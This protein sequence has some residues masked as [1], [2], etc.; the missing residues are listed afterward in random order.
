[1]TTAPKIA[2]TGWPVAHSRSP[3]VQ[4]YW[5]E[6]YGVSGTY[7]KHAVKPEEAESFY[8]NFATSGLTGGNVTVPHKEVAARACDVLD[9]AARKIGAVNT[10]WLDD[11]GRLNGTNTDG[12]GFLGNLDQYADGWDKSQGIALVLGAGGGARAVIWALLS[13]G[14]REVHIFNRTVEKAKILADE[15]GAGTFAHS[16]DKIGDY[17]SRSDLLVN[18]TSLGMSGKNPLELDLKDLPQTAVVTDIVYS[19]L[20]TDLLKQAD[21][22]GNRTVD[23]LGMLLHQAVHGFERWFGVTPTVDDDLRN[24]VLKDLGVDT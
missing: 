15:F 10:L 5:L 16:W 18:T 14:F 7:G 17:L 13:R 9:D 1:M 22:R 2:I 20:K 4:G 21:Q 6:K 8:A 12:L 19:P 23:G 11:Q 24:F 3:V